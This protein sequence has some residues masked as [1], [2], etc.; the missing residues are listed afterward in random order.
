[1]AARGEQ[2]TLDP[3]GG[4]LGGKRKEE[5]GKG[6]RE[7]DEVNRVLPLWQLSCLPEKMTK[8]YAGFTNN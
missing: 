4:Q 6:G 7:V 3:R 1:M 8:A 2:I 5:D